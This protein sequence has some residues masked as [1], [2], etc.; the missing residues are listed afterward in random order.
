MRNRQVLRLCLAV[1][2]ILLLVP[3]VARAG[4]TVFADDFEAGTIAAWSRGV[5]AVSVDGVVV[6]EGAFAARATA[7]GKPAYL[8]RSLGT[9]PT[10][11]YVRAWF[12]IITRSSPASLVRIT[13]N[14]KPLFGVGLQGDGRLFARNSFSAV[15][16]SSVAAVSDGAWHELEVHVATD[17]VGGRLDVWLDGAAIAD[18]GGPAS[19][20]DSGIT[21]I[22]IGEDVKRR[23]STVAYDDV[24]AST[25]FIQ[26]ADHQPPTA[27]A[28]VQAAAPTSMRVELSWSPSS[29]DVGVAGYSIY[30]DGTSVGVTLD[31]TFTDAGV[32]PSTTYSYTVDAFDAAGHRS[33]P[34]APAVVDVPATDTTPP[35]RPTSLAGW[36][37][38]PTRVDLTWDASTDDRGVTGYAVYRDGG[39][40]PIGTS[41]LPGYTDTTASPETEHVYTVDAVDGEGNRSPRSDP[42]TVLTPADT[43]PPS[44]PSGLSARAVS[45]REVDLAWTAA[46]DDVGVVA[47]TIY[48]DGI[49][50][51]TTAS[52]SYIDGG[53][54]PATHVVYVVDAVDAKGFHS[55]PSEAASAD[56]PDDTAPST[57]TGLAVDALTSARVE[58][59]WNGSSDDV[60]VIGY[61]VYRDGVRIATSTSTTYT[62]LGVAAAATYRYRVDAFDAAGNHSP[63]SPAVRATTPAPADA[64]APSVPAN[65]HAVSITPTGVDLDWNASSDSVGVTGYGVFRDGV[66]IATTASSSYVDASVLPGATYRY[67]VD[68]FDAADN[69]S[70]LSDPVTVDVPRP[71]GDSSVVMAAGDIACDPADGAFNGGN[72]TAGSCRQRATSD[73]LL[74][75]NPAAVLA[76]GDNQYNCAGYQAF[77]Q[78]FD[79]SWGRLKSITYPALGNHEYDGSGGTGC[80]SNASG[81][82]QYFGSRAGPVGQGWYS[83]D[84]GAWHLI[85]LNS[86]CSHVGGCGAGSTQERW[87]KADLAAR[88]AAC[89]LAF[90]HRPRYGPA[91]GDDT[92]EVDALWDDLVA[93]HADVVLSGH[94]HAYA[95]L[96]PLGASGQV[97]TD[98]IRSFVVGTGG[99]SLQGVTTGRA[100]VDKA[101]SDYGVLQLTLRTDGYDWQ[102]VHAAGENLTDAGSG[103]CH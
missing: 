91:S 6:H 84:V 10:E 20:G 26:P 15:T 38:S 36:A 35:Q 53:V 85:A 39:S 70:T 27:P 9:V 76:L 48:R 17:G 75:A 82:F 46:I 4:S 99:K 45:S 87:L 65:L 92:A 18:L 51:G 1:T 98:G 30:R 81:Y 23:T 12:S 8:S 72:G 40:T 88:P 77:R 86:E 33:T 95:R 7:A 69:H 54:H 19:F 80:A 43:T 55:G 60:A 62:D 24:A 50:I 44:P 66:E 78:S 57:P 73:L 83:F 32:E 41:A 29:D 59:S 61:T 28:G 2:M 96:K 63:K 97:T 21:G 47:Y 25:S 68:A 37:A 71:S 100:I 16:A 52:T 56:V 58:L 101:G 94:V 90:W 3:G 34:S 14:D 31:S 89:T 13:R 11:L 22:R 5:G 103:A 102:F 42:F 49:V 64:T 79:L 74:A 67:R 93:A